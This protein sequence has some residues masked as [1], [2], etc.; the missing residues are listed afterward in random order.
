ME[1]FLTLVKAIPDA[2]LD[3]PLLSR[4]NYEAG[5]EAFGQDVSTFLEQ[6][7]LRRSFRRAIKNT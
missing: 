4:V 5:I 6:A 1:Q 7:G 3:V 2:R